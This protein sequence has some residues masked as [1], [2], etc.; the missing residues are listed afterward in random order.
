MIISLMILSLLKRMVNNTM[1]TVS[2]YSVFTPNE[3]DV[4][5]ESHRI[6]DII[7]MPIIIQYGNIIIIIVAIILIILILLNPIIIKMINPSHKYK[8]ATNFI[9]VILLISL[10]IFGGFLAKDYMNTMKKDI[11]IKEIN[12]AFE[13]KT[14]K[15]T[16]HVGFIEPYMFS[17]IATY[18]AK[19]NQSETFSFNYTLDARPKVK[20]ITDETIQ[21]EETEIS[22]NGKTQTI[23]KNI[24]FIERGG[25]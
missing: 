13:T 2:N 3:S 5:S 23:I 18:Y 9:T 12:T 11:L 21:Y 6:K 15:R 7:D 1:K 24:K 19:N 14:T 4:I 25:E 17:N 10:T 22:G 20:K 16:A 8:F